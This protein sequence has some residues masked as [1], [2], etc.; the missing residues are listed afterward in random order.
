LSKH[1]LGFAGKDIDTET[2]FG[3]G[4]ELVNVINYLIGKVFDLLAQ[5]KLLKCGP[6][7]LLNQSTLL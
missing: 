7:Y 5:F 2:R 6:S 3:I 4:K 1:A